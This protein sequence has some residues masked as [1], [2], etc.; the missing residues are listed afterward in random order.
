[1]TTPIPWL[2]TLL[3]NSG[4][5][6]LPQVL[7]ILKGEMSVVGPRPHLPEY[8]AYYQNVVGQEEMDK[9]HN[10]RPGL[11]GTGPNPRIPRGHTQQCFHS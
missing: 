1:M 4:I 2:G 6:E 7:N 8:N 10:A 11:T 5:D 9:R 3:R